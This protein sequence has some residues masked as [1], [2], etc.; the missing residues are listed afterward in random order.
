MERNIYLDQLY[1][2]GFLKFKIDPK[3]SDLRNINEIIKSIENG[4]IK[5]GF[6]MESKYDRSADLRPSTIEYDASFS[7]VCESIGVIDILNE[8][9]K[10]KT[11]P[12]TVQLRAAY[13]G[14]S[15]LSW[16]RDTHKYKN[17][18]TTVGNVPPVFKA[19][20]YPHIS[21]NKPRATLRVSSGSHLR[22]FNS[23]I[24]DLTVPRLLFNKKVDIQE[25]NDTIL[26]FN[27][28]LLHS[29]L[30]VKGTPIYRL[31]TSFK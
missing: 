8:Y 6:S 14:S 31:I 11:K 10:Y 3:N 4:N 22:F 30:S 29:V 17:D 1:F 13:E 12:T 15:Y 28:G 26:I 20:Y 24:V 23:K 18:A 7:K 21:N 2:D 25:A 5:E 16:H 19:I 9:L 27:T